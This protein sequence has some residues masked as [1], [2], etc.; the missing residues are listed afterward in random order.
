[1]H[2]CHNYCLQLL[3]YG[4]T[5]RQSL[6]QVMKSMP[7]ADAKRDEPDAL[8]SKSSL[9]IYVKETTLRTVHRFHHFVKVHHFN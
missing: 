8:P 7:N 1:M 9:N 3:P 4:M 6:R 2:A 5:L